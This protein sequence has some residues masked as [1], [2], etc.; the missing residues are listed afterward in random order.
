M[1]AQNLLY[2]WECF[3]DGQFITVFQQKTIFPSWNRLL[4]L[5][6]WVGCMID[7]N[8]G[9]MQRK[10]VNVVDR[11]FAA[12]GF[13]V[14]SLSCCWA[15]EQNDGAKTCALQQ[16]CK[17]CQSN[18][19]VHHTWIGRLAIGPKYLLGISWW[20]GESSYSRS[21]KLKHCPHA[22]ARMHWAYFRSN[23]QWLHALAPMHIIV[24]HSCWQYPTP[25]IR[26]LLE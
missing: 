21:G 14:W 8:C 16:H 5:W 13:Q 23:L 26:S 9:S 12:E 11:C 15:K 10:V 1:Q 6:H 20:Y 22:N 4:R 24:C 7:C 25:T 3:E 17:K 19:I 2:K 18:P